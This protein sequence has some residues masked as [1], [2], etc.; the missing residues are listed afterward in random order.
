[1]KGEV[2]IGNM[3]RTDFI[4]VGWN[5]KRP[6]KTAYFASGRPIPKSQ[7]FCPVF[8]Q[9]SEVEVAGVAIPE[10]GGTI[11]HRW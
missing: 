4:S 6:G 11:D 2:S 7:G 1:M 3:L 9:R 8:V 5:T 10:D